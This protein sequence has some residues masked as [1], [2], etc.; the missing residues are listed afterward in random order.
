MNITGEISCLFNK[1]PPKDCLV[2]S[3]ALKSF[4]CAILI[5]KYVQVRPVTSHALNVS[6]THLSAT[7]HSQAKEKNSDAT[8]QILLIYLFSQA[9]K[10]YW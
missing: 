10:K 8:F 7:S 1:H 3:L 4:I 2:L 9:K 6:V 5:Q